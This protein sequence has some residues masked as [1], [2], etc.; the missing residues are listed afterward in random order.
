MTSLLDLR[1]QALGYLTYKSYLESPY[2]ETFRDR[3]RQPVCF[4]CQKIHP[5]LHVHH[6]TYERLGAEHDT[7]VITVCHGCHLD[8]HAV[9]RGHANG[10]ETAHFRVRDY[11]IEDAKREQKKQKKPPESFVPWQKLRDRSTL[12]TIAEL[13]RYLFLM[14]LTQKGKATPRA[15]WLRL[16]KTVDGEERWDLQKFIRLRRNDQDVRKYVHQEFRK[17]LLALEK[18]EEPIPFDI[19]TYPRIAFPTKKLHPT[20]TWTG[21]ENPLC[22]RKS[23]VLKSDS[24]AALRREKWV[25][26][27]NLI[28]KPIFETMASLRAFLVSQKLLSP[29]QEVA[30]PLAYERGLV[31]AVGE[32]E[33]WSVKAF[34]NLL[35][36]T[37]R[38]TV[39]ILKEG[40]QK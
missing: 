32:Q 4:C 15:F 37:P 38:G 40:L 11:R 8:A 22:P 29:Y 34:K 17:E 35:G 18:G 28:F 1:A 24:K 36:L 27:W 9:A 31:K 25:P 13:A 12:Q 3:T 39:R 5:K 20:V 7:D 6:I 21:M 23:L 26:L 10:L 16:V 14:G 33:L 30:T 2:W 19:Q